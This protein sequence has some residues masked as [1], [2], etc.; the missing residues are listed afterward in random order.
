MLDYDERPGVKKDIEKIAE[1]LYVKY[2][3]PGM[4]KTKVVKEISKILMDYIDILD[5]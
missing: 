2:G 5:V 3:N 4:V 1:D